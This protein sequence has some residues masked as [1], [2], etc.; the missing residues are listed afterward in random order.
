MAGH[1]L[2]IFFRIDRISIFYQLL[3]A[4]TRSV[5]WQLCVDLEADFPVGQCPVAQEESAQDIT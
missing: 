1:F 4:G 2:L 3:A 5:D